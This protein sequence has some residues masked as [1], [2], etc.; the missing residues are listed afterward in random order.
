MLQPLL[1]S[2][3]AIQGTRVILE[4]VQDF[5]ASLP[6]RSSDVPRVWS[7]QRKGDKGARIW[8]FF[9]NYYNLSFIFKN[10]LKF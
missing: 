9:F 3:T 4:A 8:I 6:I 1:A 7:A 5:A 10:K 2:E